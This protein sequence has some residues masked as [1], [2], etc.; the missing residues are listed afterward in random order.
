MNTLV[1]MMNQSIARVR[2]ISEGDYNEFVM[3]AGRKEFR[4]QI[5]LLNTII[6]GYLSAIKD[7]SSMDAIFGTN[8]IDSGLGDSEIE[9]V[10]R[11][12]N[13]KMDECSEM[14]KKIKEK[15]ST[16]ELDASLHEY[17]LQLKLF[18]AAIRAFRLHQKSR[19][20]NGTNT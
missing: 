6:R 2:K 9:N 1:E 8:L 10:T 14:M 19:S 3:K 17:K 13:E 12:I 18:N 20:K 7:K 16:V 15:C 11:Q 5:E 4:L